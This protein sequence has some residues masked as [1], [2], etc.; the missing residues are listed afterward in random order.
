LFRSAMMTR[1]TRRKKRSR[2]RPLEAVGKLKFAF[3]G[4]L[5]GGERVR[6]V[7]IMRFCATWLTTNRAKLPALELARY[8]EL[9]AEQ[10]LRS[11]DCPG[12]LRTLARKLLRSP[13]QVE[14]EDLDHAVLDLMILT[15]NFQMTQFAD[16]C[17][18]P[19]TL[20]YLCDCLR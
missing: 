14:L 16:L 11:E 13:S 5:G 12:R 6:L 3:D 20:R 4:R 10:R 15:D 9:E 1:K 17:Y 7:Q 18:V 2:P 8:G 19:G